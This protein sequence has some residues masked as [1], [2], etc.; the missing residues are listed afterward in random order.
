M[1]T[2]IIGENHQIEDN[3]V[4][5]HKPA[6]EIKDYQIVIGRNA[7]IRSGTVIYNGVRIGDNLETGHGVV[8]REENIIGNNFKIW[9]NSTIDYGCRI[10]NDVK[11]HCNVY[12]SQFTVIEDGCFLAPGVLLANDPHPGCKFYKECMQGPVIK[13]GVKIG[14]GAIILP[15]VTIGEEVLIGAGSVVTK[16]IPPRTVV[17]GNPARVIKSIDSLNCMKGLTAKPY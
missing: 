12:V 13:R 4:I 11:I 7:L 5:G 15:F 17:Y 1:E 2:I 6:R 3:V 9:N 8:I 14:M 10:G 16:D